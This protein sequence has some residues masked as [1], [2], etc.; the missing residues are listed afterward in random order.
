[1]SRRT[2][3]QQHSLRSTQLNAPYGSRLFQDQSLSAYTTKG[4]TGQY[5]DPTSGLDYYVSRY[6]DPVAGVL[7]S[8]DIKAG[9]MQGMNPYGYVS[10]NPETKNDPTGKYFVPP[11]NGNGGHHHRVSNLEIVSK[12]EVEGRQPHQKALCHPIQILCHTSPGGFRI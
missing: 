12:S 7:L 4:F 2:E 1:V 5:N 3:G 11:G 6:Y 10:N 9:N 8:A